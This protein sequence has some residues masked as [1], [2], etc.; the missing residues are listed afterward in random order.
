M[1]LIA[2]GVLLHCNFMWSSKVIEQAVPD[3]TTGSL[4]G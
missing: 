4:N 2:H 3:I 1:K